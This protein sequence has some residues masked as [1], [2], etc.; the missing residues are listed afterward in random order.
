[1][2]RFL[3]NDQEKLTWYLAIS[4][5]KLDEAR[6]DAEGDPEWIIATVEDLEAG[7]FLTRNGTK[8]FPKEKNVEW[9]CK[10]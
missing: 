6:G 1:M 4:A 5:S 7:G 3:T 10:F 8:L 2:N 9:D